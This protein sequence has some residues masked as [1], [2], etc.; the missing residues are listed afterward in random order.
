[1]V[2]H[3][4]KRKS[5]FNLKTIFIGI[6]IL[7]W[8]LM[9]FLPYYIA[10]PPDFKIGPIPGLFF[11]LAGAVHIFIFYVNAYYLYPK[12]LNLRFW[13]LYFVLVVLL[14]MVSFQL[15]HLILITWFPTVINNVTT[16][17][18][19][20]PP[21]IGIFIA[22]FIYRK[23]LNKINQEKV[24]KDQEAEKLTSELKFL[25]SQISP[26]FLFNVLTNLVSLARKKS[27][28]LEPSLLMLSELMRYMLYDSQNKRVVLQQEVEY[29]NSYIALQ[30][31]RFGNEVSITSTIS[32]L[33]EAS[34]YQI[35]PMLLIPFVEN[36]FKH[37][38]GWI[39]SPQIDIDLS[40]GDGV[41]K[42]KVSNRY[43]SELNINKDKNSGIGLRNVKTRLE[44]LYKKRY[45]LTINDK[46]NLFQI[47]LT[48]G[49]V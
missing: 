26:H 22:S 32:I 47:I 2:L 24:L 45:D 4:T 29:L 8:S 23:I 46:N 20:Y 19:I 37:G 1:M 7:I 43:D 31:L 14:L 39:E 27:D 5:I 18:F 49:L 33:E 3:V 35:E 6:H 42:F 48:L 16:Y 15:K 41:L 21:S 36:A 9:L 11:T 40:V 34:K 28:K 13:W 12:F 25:R 38:I 30:K 10:N 44:L 17:R